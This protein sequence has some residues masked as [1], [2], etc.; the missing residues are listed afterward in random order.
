MDLVYQSSGTP[1]QVM[2]VGISPSRIANKNK[3][4]KRLVTNA[5]KDNLDSQGTYE[6]DY[7]NSITKKKPPVHKRKNIDLYNPVDSNL[8][9]I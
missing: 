4:V 2:S 5:S 1:Q 8:P 6:R 3:D 7:D 9:Q